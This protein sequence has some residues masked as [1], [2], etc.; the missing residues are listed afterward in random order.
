MH[1]WD[2]YLK[3]KRTEQQDNSCKW[4]AVLGWPVGQAQRGLSCGKE[5]FFIGFHS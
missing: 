4:S 2:E 1:S 3:L 5:S